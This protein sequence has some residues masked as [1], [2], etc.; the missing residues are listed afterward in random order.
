MPPSGGFL[1][2]VTCIREKSPVD[3]A[4]RW[5]LRKSIDNKYYETATFGW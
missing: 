1:F 4:S 2:R 3:T 5:L